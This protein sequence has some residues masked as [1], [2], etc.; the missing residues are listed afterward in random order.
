MVANYRCG[1]MKEEALGLVAKPIED[2]SVRCS[3]EI[4]SNFGTTC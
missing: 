3:K 4:I 2:L 1:E